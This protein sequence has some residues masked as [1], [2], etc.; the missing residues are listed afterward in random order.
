MPVVIPLRL[1]TT[2]RAGTGLAQVMIAGSGIRRSM[3]TKGAVGVVFPEAELPAFFPLKNAAIFD[4]D[5]PAK[6]EDGRDA[7]N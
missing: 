3:A 2:I 7:L 5:G 1:V 6:G 4:F